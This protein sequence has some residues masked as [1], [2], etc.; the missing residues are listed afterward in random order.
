MG[1]NGDWLDSGRIRHTYY[2]RGVG[3]ADEEAMFPVRSL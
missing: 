3:G 1:V 2:R